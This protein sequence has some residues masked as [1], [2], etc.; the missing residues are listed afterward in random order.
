M[1]TETI[2]D[3]ASQAVQADLFADLKGIRKRFEDFHLK[4]PHVYLY[5]ER[6]ALE[7]VKKGHKKLGAKMIMERIRWEIFTE[8]KDDA[9]FKIN[10]DFVAHYAR[11]FIKNH[12]DQKEL[13]EFRIIKSL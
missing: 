10:N 11:M 3:P 6:F 13:F 9:G 8:S 4:H 12:P 1:T 7:L 2:K 5:F